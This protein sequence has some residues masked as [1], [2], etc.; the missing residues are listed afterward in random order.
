MPQVSSRPNL[1]SRSPVMSGKEMQKEL[2]TSTAEAEEEDEKAEGENATNVGK[3]GIKPETAAKAP[4][5][6]LV[7]HL[8]G[9][10]IIQQLP[11][12]NRGGQRQVQ[13]MVGLRNSVYR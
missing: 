4:H 11:T 3:K 10:E 1:H 9:M 2:L 6:H 5:I 8:L 13:T 7:V 12:H